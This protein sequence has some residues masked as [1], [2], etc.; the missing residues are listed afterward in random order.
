MQLGIHLLSRL[1][2]YGVSYLRRVVTWCPILILA[3]IIKTERIYANH[4]TMQVGAH[5]V[6]VLTIEVVSGCEKIR[7]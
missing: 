4:A 5:S 2:G 6:H 3:A 1:Y 7:D